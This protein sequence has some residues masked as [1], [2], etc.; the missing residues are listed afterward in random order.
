LIDRLG[1]RKIPVKHMI[2]MES[3]KKTTVTFSALLCSALLVSVS[4]SCRETRQPAKLITYNVLADSDQAAQRTPS[5]LKIIGDSDADVIALQEVAPWF[6]SELTKTEWFKKYP[7]PKSDDKIIC[8]RGLLILS[9]QPI[10][11]ADYG[12]LPSRQRRAYLIVETKVNG[13]T[14]K[15][16]TCHLDSFL[17]EGAMRAKQLDVFFKKLAA[18]KNAIFMGDFNFGDDAQPE[19]KHIDKNYVDLWTQVNGKKKGYTWNIEKSEMARKGSFPNEKSRRI[20]RILIKSKQAEPV[21]SKIL[22]DKPI[23][24]HAGVFPSD[25]FGLHAAVSVE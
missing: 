19:T 11:S 12:W 25:H 9:K 6:L 3:M 24:G 22:G 5:L 23:K 10:T 1:Q 15:V 20:D 2:A 4:I 7:V 13:V 14:F 8:A 16:A 17:K 21:S 18:D